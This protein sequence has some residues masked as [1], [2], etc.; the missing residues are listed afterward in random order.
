M[1]LDRTVFA[2]VRQREYIYKR[3]GFEAV[4]TSVR[5]MGHQYRPSSNPYAGLSVTPYTAPSANP[6]SSRESVRDYY[7]A[8]APVS[9]YGSPMFHYNAN[10]SPPT[11]QPDTKSV[12]AGSLDYSAEKALMNKVLQK[13]QQLE[14][15]IAEKK[16]LQREVAELQSHLPVASLYGHR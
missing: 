15:N 12:Y 14:E 2:R 3:L 10:P 6:Y 9:A 11:F 16:R 7:R 5:D 13:K 8:Q 4:Q 1:F